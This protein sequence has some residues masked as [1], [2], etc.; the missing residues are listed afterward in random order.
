M[1][2]A[3]E[4]TTEIRT[5]TTLE[6]PDF[7]VLQ[8]IAGEFLAEYGWFLLLL[9]VGIYFVMQ[10][11]S[12]RRSGQEAHWSGHGAAEADAAAVVKRQE[13]VEVARR[14]MQDELDAKAMEYRER[15]RA[16][17]EEKRKQ[18]I[19]MW[20]SMQQ[21]KSYKGNA[22]VL[23]HTEEVSTSTVV[24][25]KSDKKPLRNSGFNPLT[26][27]GGGSCAWRPGRRGPSA[28]G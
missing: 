22:K 5:Q 16:V 24:K 6:N 18:K 21:G 13:A 2:A 28:G 3:D 17:E 26:G 19:E 7:S 1:E 20:D 27:E 15:Q 12:K 8:Q 23:N 14:R 4:E 11:L 10:Q 25:P 9:C